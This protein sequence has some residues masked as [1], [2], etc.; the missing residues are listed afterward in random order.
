MKEK[1]LERVE[2]YK[3]DITGFLQ[4]MVQTKSYSGR[5]ENVVKLITSEM[6]KLGFDEVKID[7]LGNALGRMGNGEKVIFYD[8]HIDTVEVP[9]EKAFKYPP[10]AA[11]IHDGKMYG[12]GTVDEK[13]GFACMVYAAKIMKELDLL[14]G[15]TLW[16]VGSVLEEDCDGHCHIHIHDYEKIHADYAVL[17]EPTDMNIYRGHR[18]R[19]EMVVKVKGKAAHGAHCDRGDNAIYKMAKLINE[20]EELHKRLKH[21][22]FLGKGSVTVSIIES[23]APSQ[24]SVADSATIYLDRRLTAGETKESAL[25][26]IKSLPSFEKIGAEV[27]VLQYDGLGWTGFKAQQE[28][29][30]PTWVIEEN[31]PLVQ[32]GFKAAKDFNKKDTKISRW[33]FSTNGVATMGR[34]NIPTIGFAPGLEELAHSVDEY[35]IVDELATATAIYSMIPSY[36]K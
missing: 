9:D 22:D 13:A 34:Y 16:V 4:R 32:A 12:R 17:A 25:N 30:F 35:I 23:T 10:F 26:E 33:V 1:V 29:Y 2:H 14:D 11:E 3:N 21:D 8:G 20:I 28:A 7:A 18:G 36:L 6:T 24:C 31:H 5:E 19:M 27:E 15:Y